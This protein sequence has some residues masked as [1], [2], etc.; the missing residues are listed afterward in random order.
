MRRL[1]DREYAALMNKPDVQEAMKLRCEEERHEWDNC[2]SMLMQIYQQ[3][4][5][6]GE[7]R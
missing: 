5:W 7:R 1:S 6:C 2:C 4:K 3:C